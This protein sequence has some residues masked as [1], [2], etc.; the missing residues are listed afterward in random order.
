MVVADDHPIVISGMR[1]LLSGSRFFELVGEARTGAE[2]ILRCE[3]YRPDALL[4]DLRLPDLPAATICARIKERHPETAIVILTAHPEELAVRGCLKAGASACLFKDVNEQNLLAAL[5]QV[6]HGRAVID[7]RIAGAMLP[8]R[9]AGGSD[10]TLTAREHEVLLLIARGLTT[11]EIADEIGLS[12]NTVKSHSRALFT[13]LDAHNRVQA[14][15]A[16]KERNL[17]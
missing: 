13:K 10:G 1:L 11:Q 15:A 6:V 17:V 5:M 14:L 4:L 8:R 16:A 12:P 9:G 3:Q 7:P 2:A